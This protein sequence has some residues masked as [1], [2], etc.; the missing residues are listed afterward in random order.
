MK[1]TVTGSLGHISKPLTEKLVAAGH[2][3]T[4]ISSSEDKTAAIEALGAKAAIGS[5]DDVAFLS[6]AFKGADAVYAMV[7][8]NFGAPDPREFI[9]RVGQNYAQAI[10]S[11][12][13]KT[14]VQ[15]SSIGADL[16]G[17]TGPIAGLH[18]VE[19]IF[20]RL[21]G[22]AVK[23]LRAG[24]F[25]VNFYGNIDMIKHMGII[26]GNYPAGQSIIM[27]HPKDIAEAAA[28][29]FQNG[30]TGKSVKYVASDERT[31]SDAASILGAAIGKPD[32][33]WVEFTDQQSLEGMEKSG[34]PVPMAR[35]YTEM[36]AAVR[37]GILFQDF[38]KVN[39]P[40]SGKIKLEE[41]AVEFAG[42]Y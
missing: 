42:K 13:V 4:V 40:I 16:D 37:S 28:V 23:S 9:K 8:P 15:L 24:F 35:A 14:V 3:V 5:V 2:Q 21:D 18:D 7:P 10:K 41:F 39:P 33:K 22:V 36:G 29:E 26:G 1:I 17:G 19:E 20:N 38:K 31:L 27:V 30:F 12:G 32:L 25:Y 34:M 6:E 11:A